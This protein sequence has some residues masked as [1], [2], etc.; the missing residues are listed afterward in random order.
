ML[1]WWLLGASGRLRC[2]FDVA[3]AKRFRAEVLELLVSGSVGAFSWLCRSF[4][5]KVSE[6]LSGFLRAFGRLLWARQEHVGR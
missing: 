6:L 2:R 1:L 3:I 5:A 4:W